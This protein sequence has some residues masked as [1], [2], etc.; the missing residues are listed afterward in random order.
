MKTA[1]CL[2]SYSRKILCYST[3]EKYFV[4]KQYTFTPAIVKLVQ[5][6][7]YMKTS[8]YIFYLYTR[9]V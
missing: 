1:T 4:Y 3:E 6:L 8:I 9:I 5:I 7:K 2:P